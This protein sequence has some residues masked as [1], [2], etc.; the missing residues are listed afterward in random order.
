MTHLLHTFICAVQEK[1]RQIWLI[2]SGFRLSEDSRN[3][4]RRNL[5]AYK[6]AE[7][8]FKPNGHATTRTKIQFHSINL[9]VHSG[10]N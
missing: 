10:D 3:R 6:A 9:F 8:L 1:T 5:A 2:L 7:G 4:N